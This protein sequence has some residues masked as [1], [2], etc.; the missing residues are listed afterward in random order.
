VLYLARTKAFAWNSLGN[1]TKDLE[2]RKTHEVDFKNFSLEEREMIKLMLSLDP[3]SRPSA[4]HLLNIVK[5]YVDV[6]SK[7]LVLEEFRL[8]R[9]LKL[10]ENKPHQRDDEIQE[11]DLIQGPFNSWSPF[12]GALNR[13][14]TIARPRYFTITLNL[15]KSREMTYV[16]GYYF[17]GGWHI[18]VMSD[19]FSETPHTKYQKAIFT[20]LGWTP[21][22]GDSPNYTKDFS[23]SDWKAMSIVFVDALEQGNG[24]NP[25]DIE[26]LEINCQG[27][28][29][30]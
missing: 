18:E 19:K 23:S 21:P 30:Y 20:Q 17:G 9:S 6:E 24:L 2:I 22:T 1:P 7:T 13:I 12:E 4:S 25:A 14:V 26:S 3:E 5:N 16:Q 11:G 15:T 28:E 29:E 10:Y 8:K 27:L